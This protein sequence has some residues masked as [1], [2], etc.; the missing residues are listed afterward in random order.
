M[1][2][3][4]RQRSRSADKRRWVFSVAW[5]VCSFEGGAA[6]QMSCSASACLRM[7]FACRLT[8]RRGWVLG[9]LGSWS[10]SGA[11]ASLGS[12]PKWQSANGARWRSNREDGASRWSRCL[13]ADQPFEKTKKLEL[14]E[15]ELEDG[16][17]ILGAPCARAQVTGPGPCTARR[18]VVSRL[19]RQARR[20]SDGK[21]GGP[22][23]GGGRLGSLAWGKWGPR[24]VQA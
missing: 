6:L 7:A 4:A 22:N 21:A 11:S 2:N 10:W 19:V 15:L 12:M 24:C 13:G 8:T 16:L 18:R 9:D 5:A 17:G 20:A 14:D 23:A 3:W 1:R